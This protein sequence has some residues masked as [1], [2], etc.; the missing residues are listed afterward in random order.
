M[1]LLK[2]HEVN[3][4]IEF[5]IEELK[6]YDK[7]I[8]SNNIQSIE[9]YL[10]FHP[11]ANKIPLQRKILKFI[12]NH[13]VL[14]E[15]PFPTDKIFYD[16]VKLTVIKEKNPKQVDNSHSLIVYGDYVYCFKC[17][18]LIYYNVGDSLFIVLYLIIFYRKM[19][20]SLTQ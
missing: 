4:E 14:L 6:K 18:F 10:R 8:I 15:N 12:D 19:E 13:L 1:S 9:E 20:N 17:E 3:L 16:N 5:E 2:N 7:V 11:E